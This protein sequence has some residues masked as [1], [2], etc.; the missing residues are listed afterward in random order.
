[1]IGASGMV[2]DK[3]HKRKYIV[4]LLKHYF[5]VIMTHVIVFLRLLI[6]TDGNTKGANVGCH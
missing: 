1:M 6:I 5:L 2:E 3:M 4:T